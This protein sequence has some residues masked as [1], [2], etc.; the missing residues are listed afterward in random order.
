MKRLQEYK[1]EHERGQALL[2]I[3]LV[4]AVSLILV[5]SI[6]TRTT[7]DITQTTYDENALRA[8]SAAEAGVEDALLKNSGTGGSAVTVDSNANVSY[9]TDFST[10]SGGQTFS[11]PEPAL[12]GQ[13]RT[14]WLV[15]HNPTTGALTCT[16]AACVKPAQIEVCWGS[17][18]PNPIP[19][20]EVSVYYD[21]SLL[22]IATPNNYAGVKTI[23]YTADP[24]GARRSSN[25][26]SSDSGACSFASGTYTYST[27]QINMSTPL[28]CTNNFG[29]LLMVKVRMLY[30]TTTA[31]PIGLRIYNGSG[32]LPAQGVQISSTGTAGDST[33][34]VSVFRGFAEPQS[35]FDAG[36][37]SFN[38][39]TK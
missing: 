39:L 32:D 28:S 5:L 21:T 17:G 33:R 3:V 20:V 27:G 34:R 37:F 29:C 30:N 22:S 38:D 31:Q 26:F 2:I 25:N 35:V 1:R 10:P 13:S 36:V 24:S 11:H 4:L 16:S 14:F 12:S 18:T 7:T 9:T 23:R 19:A 6:S 15:S 8:F